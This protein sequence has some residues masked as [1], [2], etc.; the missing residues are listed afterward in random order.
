MY[1]V[2]IYSWPTSQKCLECVNGEFFQSETN[3]LGVMCFKAV[4]DFDGVN[5]KFF[6]SK[7]EDK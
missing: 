4:E 5:C 1:K 6:E 3:S 2:T 7:E